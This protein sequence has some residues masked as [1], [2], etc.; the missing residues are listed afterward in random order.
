MDIYQTRYSDAH[1]EETTVISNDGQTLRMVLRGVEFSGSDF[2]DFEPAEFTL[3]ERLTGFEFDHQW[4]CSCRFQ[5]EIPIR[6]HGKG[7]EAPGL[8]F[9]D[10]KLGAPE[11]HTSTTHMELHYRD[12]RCEGIGDDGWFETHLLHIQKQL[13]DGVFIKCCVNCLFSD[14]SPSGSGSFGCMAC[15]R[16]CKA[17]YLAI[18]SKRDFWP[19]LKKRDRWVRETY[20][21]EEFERRIPGTGYRG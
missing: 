13:P 5:C 11:S 1:G 6:I 20:L 12:A 15:F 4:L 3:A 21:C 19:V 17:E 8:L 18:K 7:A 16:N 9:G 14:Y 2:E 10:I